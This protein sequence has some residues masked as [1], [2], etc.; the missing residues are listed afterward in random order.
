VLRICTFIL[1]IHIY[2]LFIMYVCTYV[3]C[4]LRNNGYVNYVPMFVR[5]YVGT[6]ART[7]VCR[8]VRMYVIRLNVYKYFACVGMNIWRM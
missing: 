3:R 1:V 6:Y 2:V 4:V 7:I 8:H 5:M